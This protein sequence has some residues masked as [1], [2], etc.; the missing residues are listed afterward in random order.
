MTG[1]EI[2]AEQ[3]LTDTFV[4]AFEGAEKP[5]AAEIDSALIGE[6]RTRF[7][8]AEEAPAAVAETSQ[9]LRNHNVR[10]TDLEEAIQHLPPSERLCFLMRDVEGYSVEAI[11]KVVDL[12]EATVNRTLFSARIRLRGVLAMGPRAEAAA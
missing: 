7:P 9:D 8:L 11:A 5:A 10:R 2:E 6:L 12:P 1:N 4:Q 3:I